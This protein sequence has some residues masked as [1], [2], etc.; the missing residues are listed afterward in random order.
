MELGDHQ[1]TEKITVSTFMALLFHLGID[2]REPEYFTYV[3]KKLQNRESLRK[4]EFIN[5]L[6]RPKKIDDDDPEE[7]KN[8]TVLSLSLCLTQL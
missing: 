3:W 1:S 8:V 5:L 7:L 4:Q 6:D 2:Q